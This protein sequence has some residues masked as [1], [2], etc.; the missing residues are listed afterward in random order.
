MAFPRAPGYNNL[1]NGNFSPVIYSKQVQRLTFSGSKSAT[2]SA[3]AVP[4]T[5]IADAANTPP[6]RSFLILENI[7]SSLLMLFDASRVFH[8]GGDPVK[9]RAFGGTLYLK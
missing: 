6:N 3:E 9:Q 7:L 1:P 4:A 2:I 8:S 5:A